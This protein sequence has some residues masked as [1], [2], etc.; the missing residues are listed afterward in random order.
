MRKQ[1]SFTYNTGIY[2]LHTNM[3]ISML[4]QVLEGKG[5]EW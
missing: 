3:C 4:N 5:M 2:N 1:L